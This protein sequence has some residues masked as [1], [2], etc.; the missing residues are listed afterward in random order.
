MV[1]LRILNICFQERCTLAGIKSA[2][3]VAYRARLLPSWKLSVG[4]PGAFRHA[5]RLWG[6]AVSAELMGVLLKGVSDRQWDCLYLDF[7]PTARKCWVPSATPVRN[8]HLRVEMSWL[9]AFLQ[10]SSHSSPA[11]NTLN[12]VWVFSELEKKQQGQGSE[13]ER[14]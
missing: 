10:L 1:L 11:G 13:T 12:K 4:T 5:G 14:N 9:E 3:V 2:H 6:R 7:I 8:L